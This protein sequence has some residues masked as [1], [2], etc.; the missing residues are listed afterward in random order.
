[1]AQIQN[2]DTTGNF[3]QNQSY[4]TA[5]Q[6]Q[7]WALTQLSWNLLPTQNLHMNF[8]R[9]PN[10]VIWWL[11][12]IVSR[13]EWINKLWY[14]QTMEYYS[15]VKRNKLSFHEKTWRNLKYIC[16]S[17]RRQSKKVT[18]SMILTIWHF[19]LAVFYFIK[20]C[21]AHLWITILTFLVF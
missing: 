17:E 12:T 14:I 21:R 1:M 10:H 16:L 11:V 19:I 4:H 3:L 20:N 5:H 13:G 18:W 2:L 7:S 15:S 6:S 9:I 8:Y